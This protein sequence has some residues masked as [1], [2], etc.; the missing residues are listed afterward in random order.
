MKF[1]LSIFGLK[2]IEWPLG[3]WISLMLGFCLT[4]PNAFGQKWTSAGRI[5]GQGHSS[6][7]K[8]YQYKLSW[9]PE[10]NYFF[11]IKQVD[12]D[13]SMHLSEVIALRNNPKKMK[14][15]IYPNPAGPS[16][17]IEGD[18]EELKN[19]SITNSLGQ[20][21]EAI[22]AIN[23]ISERQIVVRVDGL[24]RGLYM[25]NTWKSSYLFTK[26]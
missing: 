6:E 22:L 11:R 23:K 10:G 21:M 24:S 3:I 5:S 18:A 4:P 20:N 25:V 9:L 2:T 17:I 26:N 16:I 15:K 7:V 19:I 8:K 1:L 13:G 14:I 12:F